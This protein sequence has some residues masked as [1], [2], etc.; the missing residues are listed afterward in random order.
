MICSHSPLRDWTIDSQAPEKSPVLR[1]FGGN[2]GAHKCLTTGPFRNWYVTAP[3]RP[4]CLNRDYDGGDKLSAF[5]GGQEMRYIVYSANDYTEL[6]SASK[7]YS[8][9]CFVDL[10]VVERVP[11]NTPHTNIGGDMA[12]PYTANDPLFWL[13]HAFIDKLWVSFQR[14]GPSFK[15]SHP[16][17]STMMTDFDIPISAVM[18]TR[19]P[20]LCYDYSPVTRQGGSPRALSRRAQNSRARTRREPLSTNRFS[21][22]SQSAI[23]LF[24]IARNL[25]KRQLVPSFNQTIE[26][27][28]N[29]AKVNCGP[30]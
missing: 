18:D 23:K 21:T 24:E 12:R 8:I 20:N 13:H 10:F 17:P 3:N 29:S 27:L 28:Q 5:V 11:H 22:I 25:R 15:T 1:E 26:P 4:H 7:S 14:R 6:A 9:A 16:E 30:T 19:S 2:S